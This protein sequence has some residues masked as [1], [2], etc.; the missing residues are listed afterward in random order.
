MHFHWLRF[1]NEIME[2]QFLIERIAAFCSS[3]LNIIQFKLMCIIQQELHQLFRMALLPEVGL[4]I[5]IEYQTGPAIDECRA[6]GLFG[7]EQQCNRPNPL[8]V[9]TSKVRINIFI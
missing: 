5:H 1:R 9:I 6:G 4:G 7:N 8:L 2:P 3:Q